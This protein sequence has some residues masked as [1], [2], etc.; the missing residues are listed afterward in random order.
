MKKRTKRLLITLCVIVG[1]IIAVSIIL[2]VVMTKER[3]T[4]MVVPRIEARAGAEIEFTDIGIRFPFG[5]GV[6]IDGLKV[7]KVMPEG[8]RVDLAA[9]KFNV[10]VSLMS[11]IKRKPEVKSVT[12][13]GAV[14][15]LANVLPGTNVAVEDLGA[16]LSMTPSDSIF[17]LDPKVSAGKITITILETGEEIELPPLDFSCRVEAPA[18]LNRAAVKDGKLVIAD[19]AAVQFEGDVVDLRGNREFTMSA[20]TSGLDAKQLASLLEE[21]GLLKLPEEQPGFTV[22][23]GTVSIEA[24]AAGLASEPS[25]VTVS[26]RLNMDKLVVDVP[27][28]P[29]VT[30][31]G[32]V[33]FT[34][35][36][37][38]SKNFAIETEKSRATVVFGMDID[39]AEKKPGYVSFD[40]QAKVDLDEMSAIA[41]VD[42]DSDKPMVIDGTLKV[43]LKGGAEPVTLRNLFPSKDGGR[44]PAKISRAWKD[45]ELAGTVDLEA[46]RLPGKEGPG[47]I[48]SL[49][50][51]AS[52]EG[53]S[54]KNIV[55][56]FDMDGRPWKASGEMKDVMP[57]LAELMLI[58][59]KGD[60]PGT[61]GPVLDGL[62]NSP[63]MT[64]NVEGRA[65]DAA[66]FQE[67]SEKEKLKA[68]K[69]SG[70]GGA[71]ME[72][73][74]A[75]PLVENSV[76]LLMLKKTFVTVKID[77]V[78]TNGAVLTSLEAQGRISNGVLRASP[79]NVEYAGGKGSGRLISDM[80]DFSKIRND[81]DI[82]LTGVDAGK[83]LSGFHSAGGLVSGTFAMKLDGRFTSGPGMDVL[84]N[85]TAT[86][87]A[88]STSGTVDLSRFMAPLKA[89][90]IKIS[91]IER[92]DF[93]EWTEK[94]V[95]DEGRVTSEV[96]RIASKNGNWDIDGSFGFDG[97]LDYNAG[98]VITPQ[99][100]AHMTDLAKYAGIIDL[101]KD[102]DG[103]I[104]L[105]LDIGGTA[106][107]PKVRL[108]QSRAK[109]NAGKKLLDDAKDK[110]K[111]LF[112]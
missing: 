92:F 82:D 16:R 19:L 6:R 12:L 25:A 86:G 54:V 15:N 10:D 46:A 109:E 58:A 11:L 88:T 51:T 81:I 78:I 48:S 70:G 27:Q 108:D 111:G 53:G 84:K 100:Q 104:L 8:G 21:K 2:R 66:A 18:D 57:A 103:N 3:L 112:K 90:G 73:E 32:S 63:D 64:I 35:S 59:E 105:M 69:S 17:I 42:E 43:V 38:S 37:I 110:L 41:P 95:I 83:A 22:E 28:A 24:R 62:V 76:T 9:V 94:F 79:V 107:E 29:R 44:T 34:D 67:A 39:K 5:F 71:P 97:T 61:F 89:T 60:M 23:S 31:D 13:G 93:H 87:R 45:L 77:S 55:A 14:L 74:A 75:N 106:K 91:S 4:A 7:S 52:I 102:D 85:L 98:L 50:T 33:D 80:R 68:D 99:Q 20:K 72:T 26:G 36:R 65:F 101:F 1:V 49:K 30:A 40:V 96:W 56:S 47:S